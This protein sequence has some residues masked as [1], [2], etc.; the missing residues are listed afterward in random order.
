MADDRRSPRKATNAVV[1]VQLEPKNDAIV[2]N[3][4]EGGMGFRALNPVGQSGTIRFSFLENGQ[5]I[6]SIG[7]LVWI[8]AAKKNGGLSFEFLSSADRER[9]RKWVGES[10]TPVAAGA[11]AEPA[12]ATRKEPTVTPPAPPQPNAAP[13]PDFQAPNFPPNFPPPGFAQPGIPSAASPSPQAAQPGFALFEDA[14][15]RPRYRWDQGIPIANSP[16]K[17]FRGFLTGAIVA[18]IVA[19]ILLFAYSNPANP[20]RVLVSERIGTSPAPQPSAPSPPPLAADPAPREKHGRASACRKTW[21]DRPRTF[22]AQTCRSWR[23]GLGSCPT[24]SE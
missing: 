5:R 9:I 4:S 8:D 3:V 17:F 22:I 15:Q 12:T 7:K 18:A 20:L 2:L 24:I 11:A 21:R 14:P 6:D 1:S 10:G 19:G 23:R 16:A 13:R